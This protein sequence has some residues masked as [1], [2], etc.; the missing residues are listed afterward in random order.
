MPCYILPTRDFYSIINSDILA[1]VDLPINST[2]YMVNSFDRAKY[3]Y[4]IGYIQNFSTTTKD[5]EN[6]Y[7]LLTFN[8]ALVMIIIYLH[9]FN[10]YTPNIV[11]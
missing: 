7:I 11:N 5:Y 9:Q 6:K 8:G 2:I 3:S 4:V 10:S 1:N